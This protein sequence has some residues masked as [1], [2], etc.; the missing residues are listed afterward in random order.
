MTTSRLITY[1][2]LGIIGGLLLENKLMSTRQDIRNKKDKLDK[3]VKNL[4]KGI[5][6]RLHRA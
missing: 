5:D 2:I 6:K 1:G 4:K 3:S